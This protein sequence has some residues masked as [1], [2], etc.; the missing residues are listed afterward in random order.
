LWE[1]F[2]RIQSQTLTGSPEASGRTLDEMLVKESILVAGKE[3]VM[4]VSSRARRG[5]FTL[6]E[7][8]VVIAIIGLLMA[9]LLPALG[10]VREAANRMSC[11]NNMKQVGVAILGFEA[12]NQRFP[13]N[14]RSSQ[15][16]RQGWVTTVQ[17]RLWLAQ[18]REFDSN[19][20]QSRYVPVPVVTLPLQGWQPRYRR[21]SDI[22]AQ[23]A[24]LSDQ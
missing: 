13:A 2:H 8:L 6:I 21:L 11:A 19:R 17:L 12:S 20:G 22:V 16:F 3:S 14:I 4:I 24:V 5:G 7:L 23:H 10:M 1:A 15:G 9:L 18:P